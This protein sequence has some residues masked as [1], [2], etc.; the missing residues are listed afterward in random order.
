MNE[1]QLAEEFEKRGI[2][3]ASVQKRA[4]AFFVDEIVVAIF[5]I[6]AFGS[7]LENITIDSTNEEIA[8]V[9]GSLVMYVVLL[10]IVYQA[11]FIWM[12][13]A[14]PGKMFMKIKVIF[15]SSIDKPSFFISLI[16]SSGRIV[17]EALF[18][19]GFIWAYFNPK[20]QAWQDLVA[21][22]LVIDA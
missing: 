17:S 22:T 12:Y 6:F 4:L 2:T 18:Y 16:R 8:T 10:K 21:D 9:L 13:G 11:F 20:R 1:E 5:S 7:L 3:L 14:T 15:I 19:V